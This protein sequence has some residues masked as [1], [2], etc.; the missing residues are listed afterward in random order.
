TTFGVASAVWLIV[1]QW[2]A[3]ALGGYIA[4][5]LRTKWAGVH[6]H[7]VFF[8]DT[9]HGLVAWAVATAIVTTLLFSGVASAVR[10]TTQVTSS[11]VAGVAQGVTEGV[12][13]S[14]A[15]GGT[16][17]LGYFTDLLF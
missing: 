9:A 14:A 11:L 3:A 17:A 16:D 2:L 13:S 10:G 5:R 12:A 4:G 1:V 15:L 7:E 6:T 8:R